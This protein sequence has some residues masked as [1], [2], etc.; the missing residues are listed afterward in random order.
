MPDE[1]QD[2]VGHKFYKMQSQGREQYS[3]ERP[4]W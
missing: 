4:Q 3:D 1:T 2:N